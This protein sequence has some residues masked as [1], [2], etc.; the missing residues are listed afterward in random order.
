MN[1]MRKRDAS[2]ELQA[3]TAMMRN[4]Q[5]EADHRLALLIE[6]EVY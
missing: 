1:V 3:R 5:I 6:G 4:N 2:V